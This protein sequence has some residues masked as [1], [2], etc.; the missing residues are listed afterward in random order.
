MKDTPDFHSLQAE[1]QLAI[2]R[3]R[4]LFRMLSVVAQSDHDI[5]N[6][7]LAATCD[8][9]LVAADDAQRALEKLVA[10]V[11]SRGRAA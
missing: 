6:E 8:S 5:D 10:R 9:G 7:T 1:A 3:L 11:F 2:G 4:G